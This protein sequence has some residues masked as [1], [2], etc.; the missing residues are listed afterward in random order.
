MAT[1]EQLNCY[2]FPKGFAWGAATAAYQIEGGW[3]ADGKGLNVWDTFTHQG[4]DRV[5][6]NQTGDVACGSYTLWEEDLKCIKQLGL[7]YY[8]FSISWSRLLPDGTTGFINQKGIDYYNKVINSLLENNIIPVVTL[9]HFDL[10]QAVEDQGGWNCEKTIEI[11]NHYAQFCYETFGDRVKFWITIN[12]PHVVAKLGYEEGLFAPGKKEPGLGAYRAAHNMLKAHA[13]A[14]HTYKNDFKNKQKGFV[15]IAIDSDW[16]EPYDPNSEKDKEATERYLSF[17]VGWFAKPI[18]VDGDYPE[19][20]K[21]VVSKRSKAQGLQTSRLPEF[22]NEE[23]NM[24]K[25]TA[26][27]FCLNYYTS[28]KIRHCTSSADESS[29]TS[30][31]AAERIK[32]PDWPECGVEWLAVVPWGLR[33]LLAYIKDTFGNPTIYITENGFAQNESPVIK[34]VQRWTYFQETLTEILKA[35]RLDDVDVKG[36][37]CWC[38]L[39]NFE[40]ISG[41]SVR[42]GLFHVDFDNAELPRTPYHS[43]IEYSKI[44]KRNALTG[45]GETVASLNN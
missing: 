15:S 3:D 17:Y 1:A 41:F 40:W 10:P 44:V 8:R 31:I 19:I 18:F 22:T 16:A 42:F 20:M 9:Y 25:G 11:F 5:F 45:P 34:D 4:G 13:K 29:C 32:D 24:I 28:R 33:K 6:K 21:T 23:K 35:I 7:T 38:L 27:F 12:E 36:Y 43:A 26:D 30:D 39:D 14:W 2:D 37:F